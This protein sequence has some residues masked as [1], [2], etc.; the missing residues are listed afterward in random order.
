MRVLLISFLFYFVLLIP[1]MSFVKDSKDVFLCQI[2]LNDSY[3]GWTTNP[4]WQ[5]V[6]DEL[7][8]RGFTPR[9][10]DQLWSQQHDLPLNER[11]I[12]LIC[13]LALDD[14]YSNWTS[15]PEYQYFSQEA[16]RRG[17][18][19]DDCDTISFGDKTPIGVSQKC[20]EGKNSQNNEKKVIDKNSRGNR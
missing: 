2:A 19:I 12:L 10:C 16:K 14:N 15:D 9:K 8:R 4:E 5:Y 13:Q 6:I 7:E 20:L 11:D 1:S 17:C 3:T 18:S